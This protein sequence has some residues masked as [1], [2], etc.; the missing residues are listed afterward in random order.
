[1]FRGMQLSATFKERRKKV[2]E[3][4]VRTSD[5]NLVTNACRLFPANARWG[6]TE[7]IR[8]IPSSFEQRRIGPRQV[9]LKTENVMADPRRTYTVF[10]LPTRNAQML[11]SG[12]KRISSL[13]Q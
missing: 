7:S 2:L 10:M 1:M 3:T 8:L 13:V 5:D 9:W 4:S 6:M 11:A 12:Q